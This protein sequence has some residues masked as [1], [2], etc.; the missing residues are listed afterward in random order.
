MANYL[1]MTREIRFLPQLIQIGDFT[2]SLIKL[3]RYLLSGTSKQYRPALI[4]SAK[5]SGQ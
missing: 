5:S 4:P 3:E 1:S 2:E